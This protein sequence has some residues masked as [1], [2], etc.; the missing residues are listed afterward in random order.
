MAGFGEDSIIKSGVFVR[1]LLII[2]TKVPRIL[3]AYPIGWY[4]VIDNW[5]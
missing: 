4:N 5:V 3:P 2:H 1:S